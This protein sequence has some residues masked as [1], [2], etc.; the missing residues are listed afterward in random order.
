ML[1]IYIY[2]SQY[3]FTENICIQIMQ[4]FCSQAKEYTEIFVQK[5]LLMLSAN[6]NHKNKN[7]SEVKIIFVL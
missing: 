3:F 6:V 5:Q 7:K 1:N 4:K 2:K